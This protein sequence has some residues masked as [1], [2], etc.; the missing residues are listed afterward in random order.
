MLAFKVRFKV[1]FKARSNRDVVD[2][3]LLTRE[4]E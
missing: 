3:Q 2:P 4:V 1:R